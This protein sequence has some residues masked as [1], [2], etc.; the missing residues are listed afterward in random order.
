LTAANDVE[1]ERIIRAHGITHVALISPGDF[2]AE[3]VDALGLPPSSVAESFGRRALEG[4]R[5]PVWL[6]AIPYRVP[7]QFYRMQ[8]RVALYAVD[9]EI[10]RAESRWALGMARLIAGD[11][12]NGRA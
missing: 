7:Q 4:R 9:W 12:T 10:A 6:R 11:E 2:T 8:A 1:A 5:L 3:Y